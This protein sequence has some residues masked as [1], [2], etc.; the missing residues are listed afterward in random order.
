MSSLGV[1]R[2][3]DNC[4]DDLREGEHPD[5][6]SVRPAS[7]D[8]LPGADQATDSTEQRECRDDACGTRAV[9]GREEFGAVDRHCRKHHAAADAGKEREPPQDWS[10][11][12]KR[13]NDGQRRE[14][15]RHRDQRF[16]AMRIGESAT[17]DQAECS[18]C[19]DNE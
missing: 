12:R 3:D 17:D 7:V 15:Q 5:H 13:Q 6:R 10:A 16:T 14:G 11:E 19:A 1:G 8:E 2:D 9:A 18:G 4:H